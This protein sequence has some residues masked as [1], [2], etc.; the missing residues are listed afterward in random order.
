MNQVTNQSIFTTSEQLDQL[1]QALQNIQNTIDKVAEWYE[2]NMGFKKLLII[3][4][5]NII[6]IILVAIFVPIIG[7]LFKIIMNSAMNKNSKNIKDCAYEINSMLNQDGRH[8]K[9]ISINL[10]Q[11]GPFAQLGRK[12]FD[13]PRINNGFKVKIITYNYKNIPSPQLPIFT[14]SE[15]LTEKITTTSNSPSLNNN[16]KKSFNGESKGAFMIHGTYGTGKTYLTEQFATHSFGKIGAYLQISCG[17]FSNLDYL[18]SM[19]VIKNIRSLLQVTSNKIN[20]PNALIVLNF[21]ETDTHPEFFRVL[22]NMLDDEF[23]AI[24]KENQFKTSRVLI[25]TTNQTENLNSNDRDIQKVSQR[26]EKFE[27]L[28]YSKQEFLSLLNSD[29]GKSWI[30]AIS[31]SKNYNDESIH[32]LAEQL[33]TK[34][35]D[36]AERKLTNLIEEITKIKRA[37]QNTILNIMNYMKEEHSLRSHSSLLHLLLSNG[38]LEC[39]NHQYNQETI[40]EFDNFLSDPATND[41]QSLKEHLI[42]NCKFI[43]FRAIERD[44]ALPII[45]NN[46]NITLYSSQRIN[47]SHAL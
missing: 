35:S 31:K 33:K 23:P 8:E 40:R 27:C 14:N 47:S 18:Q 6:P 30:K 3:A 13:I 15:N 46:I 16:T 17:Q 45:N 2:K 32:N 24:T 20:N 39:L 1:H 19:N 37:G 7:G 41:S 36:F 11:E 21:D 26:F 38:R 9:E 10:H 12:I 4:C 22:Q 29:H 25:C 28:A 44:I 34:V 43:D 5:I 42:N